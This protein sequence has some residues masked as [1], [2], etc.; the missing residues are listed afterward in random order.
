ML[1]TSK[2]FRVGQGTVGASTQ[3]MLPELGIEVRRAILI[4]AHGTNTGYVYIGRI[5]VTIATGF[6][7]PAGKT[8]RL[9]TNDAIA[10]YIVASAADQKYSWF[11]V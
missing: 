2:Q 1:E 3:V 8:L 6:Q 5:G 11:V 10:L 4:C 7:I 9:E